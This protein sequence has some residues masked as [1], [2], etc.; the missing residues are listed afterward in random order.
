V[1]RAALPCL[2]VACRFESGVIPPDATVGALPDGT[3]QPVTLRVEAWLDGRSRLVFHGNSVHWH[4]L[5][6]AA[7]GRELFV[8]KP[9][10]VDRV[11]WFPTWPDIPNAENRD[12][13]CDSSS[14]DTLPIHIPMAPTTT[15][16]TPIAVRAQPS[17][18]QQ[19]SAENGWTLIVELSDV[20]SA[21]SFEDIVDIT[22]AYD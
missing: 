10:L 9:T 12:C 13:D 1:W 3:P 17:V 4:H 21:G 5:E 15:T 16:V 7:P 20:G 11:E 14:Y 22:L 19:P 18:I 6:F 2:L 8:N